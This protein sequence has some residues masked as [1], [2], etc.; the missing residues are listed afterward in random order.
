MKKIHKQ[1][2]KAKENPVFEGLPDEVK[3]PKNFK[4]IEKK[5]ANTMV[6]DHKHATIKAFIKCKRCQIKVKKKADM[7]KEL[8]FKDFAQYQDWKKIISIIINKQNLILYDK[9]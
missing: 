6:S 1:I 5:L 9:G 7:I 8:G 2:A 3:D 4:E